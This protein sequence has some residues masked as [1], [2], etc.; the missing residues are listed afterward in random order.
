MGRSEDFVLGIDIGGT[1]IRGVLWRNK[2][3]RFYE[4]D[5][6]KTKVDF[7]KR[8]RALIGALSLNKDIV[9]VGIASAGVIEGTV[10]KKS[11]NIK[12][13]N[14][15]DFA[16]LKISRIK[17]DND[18]R[19]FLRSEMDKIKYK[20]VLG[21]T[22]GT[23]IGRA[24][25]GQKIKAFEYPEEWEREYQKIRDNKDDKKLAKFL[26]EKLNMMIIKIKPDAIILGGGVI[27]RKGFFEKIKK[28]LKAKTIRSRFGAK[29]GAIGAAK[30]FL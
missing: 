26:G 7:L 4:L 19:A 23:G 20:K 16:S 15:F 5:T 11:P 29:A 13:L 30:L 10:V 14:S 6:P 27:G 12:Y 22:I 1:K 9:G 2:I 8:I 17:V 21:V 3:A 24:Y 25:S 18:A 28:E